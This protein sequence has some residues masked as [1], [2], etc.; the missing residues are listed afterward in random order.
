MDDP[1][2]QFVTRVFG[3]GSRVA[4]TRE[5]VEP[6]KIPE[7]S[8]RFLL[9]VGLPTGEVA[10]G[11]HLNAAATLPTLGEL[12]PDRRPTLDRSW[13]AARFLS[14][15]YDTGVYLD[16]DDAGTVWNIDLTG[17]GNA[18]FVNSSVEQFGYF[19][20]VLNQPAPG[21]EDSPPEARRKMLALLRDELGRADAAALAVDDC[22]WAFALED[23]SYY[24]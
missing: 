7:R 9:E 17:G 18:T 15:A 14:H 24:L 23:A 4:P 13:D 5:R 11:I 6:L 1:I 16:E 10:F 3:P 12:Y 20:A 8:K 19:L 21:W 22:Y 2:F